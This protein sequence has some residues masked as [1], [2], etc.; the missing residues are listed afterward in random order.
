[1]SVLSVDS[2][3]VVV[4]SVVCCVV[5]Q[6]MSCTRQLCRMNAGRNNMEQIGMGGYNTHRPPRM[7]GSGP[8]IKRMKPDDDSGT[9]VCLGMCVWVCVF[10]I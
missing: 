2:V 10:E 5:F 1:M 4:V 3:C 6:V 8:P 9:C 7:F